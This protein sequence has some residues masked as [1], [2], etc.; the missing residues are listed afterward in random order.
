MNTRRLGYGDGTVHDL[1]QHMVFAF[2][3]ATRVFSFSP[4]LL[5]LI[6]AITLSVFNCLFAAGAVQNQIQFQFQFQAHSSQRLHPS[7][8]IYPSHRLHPHRLY[9]R[10]RAPKS[11]CIPP[12]PSS[13]GHFPSL[14]RNPPPRTTSSRARS[15]RV[16]RAYV[17]AP[18]DAPCA[19]GR[20][21][22]NPIADSVQRASLLR[23][24]GSSSRPDSVPVASCEN[25]AHQ[26]LVH[27]DQLALPVSHSST[28]TFPAVSARS[29]S[30]VKSL[31]PARSLPSAVARTPSSYIN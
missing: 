16:G 4:G 30:P 8:H 21:T 3:G 1:A 2:D 18:A 10:P 27:P 28:R 11:M 25:G 17:D 12:P 26:P 19:R 14:S 13:P 15:P 24:S 20:N 22:A 29:D 5:L 9:S 6:P 31:T 23:A 7:H